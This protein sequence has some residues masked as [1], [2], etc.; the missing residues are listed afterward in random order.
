MSKSKLNH[1]AFTQTHDEWYYKM[2]FHL[3]NKILTP[4]AAHLIYLDI[5]DTRSAAKIKKLRE[6][7]CNAHFD[8]NRDIIARI[9]SV[10]SQE[11]QQIQ[12]VDLLIGAV[13]Y[14]NRTGLPHT[15]KGKNAV[16]D[17]IK[18]KSGYSL[19]STTLMREEKLNIFVWTPNE[20]KNE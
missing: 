12:M 3:L 18:K 4:G 9:Q 11:V 15:N 6:V 1:A 20:D 16:V 2:Y 14:A 5:K 17:L 13:S 19:Q 10:R 8:F 7:L